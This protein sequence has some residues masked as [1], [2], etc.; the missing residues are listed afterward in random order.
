MENQAV[1]HTGS[2]VYR[3]AMEFGFDTPHICNN[4]LS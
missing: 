3:N 4:H 2:M 1:A